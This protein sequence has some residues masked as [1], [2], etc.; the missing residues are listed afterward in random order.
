MLGLLAAVERYLSLDQRELSARYERMVQT[1][2]DAVAEV[3]GVEGSRDW[4]SEAG[5]PIPRA[6]VTLGSG[7]RHVQGALW[8]GDPRIAVAIDGDEALLINPETLNPG[9]E[10][11]VAERLVDVLEARGA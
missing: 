4:P 2:L 3:A 8:S 9:E 1:V 5:Q 11:T 7:A 6:R 10:I